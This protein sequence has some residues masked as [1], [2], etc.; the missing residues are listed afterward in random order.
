MFKLAASRH[1]GFCRKWNMTTA[2]VAA[3]FYVLVYQIWLKYVKRRPSYGDLC[4]FKMAAGRHLEFGRKWNLTS[5]P[6]AADP[7]LSSY[8]IWWRYLEG[9]PSYHVL[10]ALKWRPAAILDFQRSEIEGNSVS[11]TSV[12]LSQPNFVEIYAIATE[13]WP[14][15]WIFKMAAAAI[16]GF[17]NRFLRPPT[18]ANWWS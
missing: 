18:T 7:Y 9:R 6:V 11:R 15:T 16:L 10:C 3:D 1:L 14:L 8:Q 13:L 12:F 17:D 4:V 5:G 2:K